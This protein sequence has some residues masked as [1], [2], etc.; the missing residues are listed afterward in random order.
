SQNSFWLW[1]KWDVENLSFLSNTQLGDASYVRTKLYYNTFYNLLSAYDDIT[2]SSQ[3]NNGRF[4]SYYDDSARGGS[5]E[6]GTEL[7]P[8]NTLKTAFH[9]RQDFHAEWNH[10][11]PTHPTMAML[12]PRQNQAQTTWS[13]AGEDTFHVT[14][15]FDLVAG[16]SYDKYSINR[17]EEWDSGG[18]FIYEYPKG[19]SDAL[20]WQT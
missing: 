9:Y 10:N 18:G 4:N 19:G 8:M 16:I 20:N 17:A 12:E 5:V 13:I 7:I 2:Y 6:A 15:D 3:S 14:P 1:P 11:R